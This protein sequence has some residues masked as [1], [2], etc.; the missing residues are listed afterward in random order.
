VST[1]P[2]DVTPALLS[3][4][5][6]TAEEWD[7][8]LSVLG[9]TPNIVELGIFSALWSEH[10]SY[11]TSRVF[12]KEFP[13]KGS[14]VLQG[15]GE[16][17]GAV[18]IGDSLAVVFKM[19]SHNHPSFIEP[20]QGAATGVGGI[21]RD[22][23]T[24]GARPVA[25]LDPLFFG[26]LEA[27]RMHSLVDGVVRGISG[28][29]N[30]I[31]I[32]T[33][34]GSTFFHPSYAKNILVN[35]MAVGVVRHDRIFRA[36]AAG[37]G[38]PVLYVGSKTGRDGIHGASMASD[39]FDDEKAKRRPTVQVGD[40]FVEKLVLE[41][42][43][44]VLEG[45][46][47]VAIQDMGA[48]GLTSSTFEMCSRGGVGM[49]LDLSSVPTREEGI[50]PYELMLSESQERMVIVAHKG[51]EEEVASVFRKWGVDAEVIGEVIT[52]PRMELLFGG[53]V[54]ADLP[55]APLVEDAPVYHRPFVLP[56]PPRPGEGA[57]PL[58]GGPD[59]RTALRRL[60]AS[61]NVSAKGWISSQYDWSVQGDTVAGP[62]ADAAVLRV[63]GSTKGLALAVA[64]N[65]RFVAADPGLGAAHA[66]VE[67][68]LNCAVTGARPL[69]VTD[70]LNF[71]NPERPEILGQFVAA[72]R[73]ISDACR[74]LDTPVISGNVSLYNET[75]GRSI[76]PTPTIG[77]VG[78]LEDVALAVPSHFRNEGDL[79]VLFGETRD[80]MG[81]S[82]YLA[83]VLGREDG[84]C[85]SLDLDAARAL[86]DL[87][88][89]LAAE[90]R[91]SSAHDLSHGGLAVAVAEACFGEV[92]LGADL[93]LDTALLPTPALFS[94]AAPRVL[95]SI[96]PGQERPVVAAARRLG[97][98]TAFLGRV[99]RDGLRIAINGLPAIVDE[100]GTLERIWAGTFG[101]AMEEA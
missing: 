59:D 24:M 88:V 43:L 26:P 30:C 60:L 67:A 10:C 57:V 87:L 3:E 86:V 37:P 47:V 4:H 36:K 33:V 12:L 41:G 69:A 101:K 5:K 40:P 29:G 56:S 54:V 84:P 42:V 9:R 89:E 22:I 8:I 77:M 51:R 85:P 2:V 65:P 21:L 19:E 13:T 95:A 28:Y 50:T 46:A 18:D 79:V 72:V 31:G 38:N 62:G 82:E 7:R 75:D 15:P 76:L 53:R 98:P 81:A 23:F 71:G 93:N 14:R 27:P 52:E 39:V 16:N 11:K 34:G 97:V 74:A 25:V 35:V 94:E 78:L 92:P 96:P 58:A 45:D 90:R 32:P 61:P 68:A 44:E 66:V 48:A 80:E 73:G 99:T 55:I 63:K 64:V 17:A 91:L 70:C 1:S 83:A 20:Y 100:T 49:R 6:L